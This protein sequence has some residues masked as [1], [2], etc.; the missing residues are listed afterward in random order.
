MYVSIIIILVH[1][2]YIKKAFT[3]VT[4]NSPLH[5]G[6]N[7]TK[8]GSLC[9]YLKTFVFLSFFSTT[10]IFRVH[11]ATAQVGGVVTATDNQ[12]SSFLVIQA[13]HSFGRSLSESMNST[14]LPFG[15]RGCFPAMQKICFLLKTLQFSFCTLLKVLWTYDKHLIFSAPPLEETDILVRFHIIQ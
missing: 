12:L 3:F 5:Q 6:L 14:R 8:I 2:Q 11:F 15:M 13:P 7:I 1:Q 9:L 4:I 10:S